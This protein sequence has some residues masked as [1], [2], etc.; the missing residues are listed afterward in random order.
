MQNQIESKYYS[1]YHQLEINSILMDN[2]LEFLKRKSLLF[3]KCL[4]LLREKERTNLLIHSLNACYGMN[5]SHE[6][7]AQPRSIARVVET[8]LLER[9]LLP[10]RSALARIW[11][12]EPELEMKPQYSDMG[13]AILTGI[14]MTTLNTCPKRTSCS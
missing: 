9:S 12:Q 13:C 1:Y 10:L 5:K 3:L 6:S 14:L 11:S 4:F 2:I 8:Q 7:R